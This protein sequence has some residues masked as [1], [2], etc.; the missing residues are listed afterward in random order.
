[1]GTPGGNRGS[2]VTTRP[3]RPV[4]NLSAHNYHL[5]AGVSAS[6]SRSLLQLPGGAAT[7][8]VLSEFGVKAA[9]AVSNWA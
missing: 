7:Q 3:S 5:L 9:D 2:T 6:A 4:T 1:M 8:A